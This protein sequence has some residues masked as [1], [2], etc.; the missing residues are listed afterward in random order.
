MLIV[1]ILAAVVVLS[2]L[3]YACIASVK[4]KKNALAKAETILK[5]LRDEND[6]LQSIQPAFCVLQLVLAC[7]EAGITFKELGTSSAELGQLCRKHREK[8]A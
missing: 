4:K 2:L 3:I 7:E 8:S 6:Q 1:K 5:N